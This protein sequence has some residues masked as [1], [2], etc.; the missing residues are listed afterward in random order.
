MRIELFGVITQRVAIGCPEKQFRNKKWLLQSIR[1]R[2]GEIT[3]R[4]PVSNY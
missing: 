3:L 1:V 2:A 4:N